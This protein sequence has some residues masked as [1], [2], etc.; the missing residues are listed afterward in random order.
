MRQFHEKNS[1][2]QMKVI[3]HFLEAADVAHATGG[4]N[5]LF[6]EGPI[7]D[8][9]EE[10]IQLKHICKHLMLLINNSVSD[11]A[12]MEDVKSFSKN[13]ITNTVIFI[14]GVKESPATQHHSYITSSLYKVKLVLDVLRFIDDSVKPVESKLADLHHFT[15]CLI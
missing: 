11:P 4:N 5:V 14:K 10:A 13:A 7:N 2:L 3:I 6:I 12:I 9:K 15:S 1:A 8:Y